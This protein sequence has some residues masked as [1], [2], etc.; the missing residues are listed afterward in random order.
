MFG[1]DFLSGH[2]VM[3]KMQVVDQRGD[4]IGEVTEV[5]DDVFVVDRPMKRDL[6]IPMEDV[7]KIERAMVYLQILKQA[8]DRQGWKLTKLF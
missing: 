7:D 4:Y 3:A 5:Y 6:I 2:H 8:V 1:K